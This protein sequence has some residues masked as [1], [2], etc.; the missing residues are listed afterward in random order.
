ME[1]KKVSVHLNP[2]MYST[3]VRGRNPEEQELFE[4]ARRVMVVEKQGRY[5][6]EYNFHGQVVKTAIG[7][8][9]VLIDPEEAP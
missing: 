8:V 6:I 9:W 4:T 7:I 1:K 5:A 3:L 2:S